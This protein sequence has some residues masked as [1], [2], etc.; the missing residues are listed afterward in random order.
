MMNDEA[1]RAFIEGAGPWHHRHELREGIFTQSSSQRDQKDLSISII[2]PAA[3]FTALTRN[4]F[5]N[6]LEGRR[7]LDCACNSGGYCFAA[8]D[9]GA[10][11]AFGF[12]I[13]EHWIR[14]AEFVAANRAKGAEG[15]RF[16]QA[17]LMSVDL[18]RRGYDVTFFNGI[19]YHLSSPV[20]GLKIAADATKELLFMSTAVTASE[21]DAVEEP[22]MKLIRENPASLMAG[23][24][25]LAWLPS[26]PK[27]LE[28]TL[29]WLGFPEFRILSW[30]RKRTGYRNPRGRIAIVAAREKGRLADIDNAAPVN[31]VIDSR[32]AAAKGARAAT[33]TNA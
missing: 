13:R 30:K 10:K 21:P 22:G 31:E 24:Q 25:T 5:P 7:F 8:A 14:Q 32:A 33:S 6:G 28:S 23:S 18:P 15:V 20:G 4:V 16:A 1:L 27:V 26:G 29:A 11:E 3:R 12:D 2:D 9:A 17:D 19:L